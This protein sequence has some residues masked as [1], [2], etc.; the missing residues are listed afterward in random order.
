MGRRE[1]GFGLG[2][3][4]STSLPMPSRAQRGELTSRLALWG[5]KQELTAKLQGTRL[6]A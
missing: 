2:C 3:A 6:Q 1:A 5:L 4:K